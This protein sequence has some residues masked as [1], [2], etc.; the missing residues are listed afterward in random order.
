[1]IEWFNFIVI[2][3]HGERA[4]TVAN[5]TVLLQGKDYHQCRVLDRLGFSDPQQHNCLLSEAQSRLSTLPL[6]SRWLSLVIPIA[7]YRQIIMLDSKRLICSDGSNCSHI[8]LE[9]YDICSIQ[10]EA[11]G[12]KLIFFYFKDTSYGALHVLNYQSNS[13]QYLDFGSSEGVKPTL[14]SFE[15]NRGLPYLEDPVKLNE[16]FK[17]GWISANQFGQGL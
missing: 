14:A 7:R 17:F 13:L 11:E 10:L 15:H 4:K 12:F 9:T 2:V 16:H 6:G 1:M 8:S 5:R 3:W